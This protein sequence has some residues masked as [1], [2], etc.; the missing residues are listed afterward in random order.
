LDIAPKKSFCREEISGQIK[1]SSPFV[2]VGL[3]F[4]ARTSEKYFHVIN[5]GLQNNLEYR[6]NY[7][8]RTLFSFIPLFAMLSL[9][10]LAHKI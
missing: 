6:F 1:F 8:T 5:I 10:P 2:P 9:S 7:L 4:P 3:D